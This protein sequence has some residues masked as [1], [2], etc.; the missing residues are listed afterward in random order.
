MRLKKEEWQGKRRAINQKVCLIVSLCLA[1]GTFFILMS[2]LDRWVRCI[3]EGWALPFWI[4]LIFDHFY[5]FAGLALVLPFTGFL[6]ER[7]REFWGTV[8]LLATMISSLSL[9]L[10]AVSAVNVVFTPMGYCV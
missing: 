2:Y 8:L 6:W 3:D 10:F 1:V 9:L 5:C 4:K 7:Q